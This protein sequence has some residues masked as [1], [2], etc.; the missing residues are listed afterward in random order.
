MKLNAILVAGLFAAAGALAT[1]APA[2]AAAA[3]EAETKTASKKKDKGEEMV[4]VSERITGSRQTRKLCHS[5]EHWDAIKAGSQETTR[6]VQ[7][8]ISGPQEKPEGGG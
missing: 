7:R 8:L 4:C 5:R 1:G 3:D 6:Q 2:F